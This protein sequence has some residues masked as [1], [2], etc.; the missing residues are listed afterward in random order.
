[1]CD[2]E[3]TDEKVDSASKEIKAEPG[4]ATA[5]GGGLS[6]SWALLSGWEDSKPIVYVDTRKSFYPHTHSANIASALVQ[7]SQHYSG[8]RLTA[9]MSL[10]NTGGIAEALLP[11]FM[12]EFSVEVKKP[13]EIEEADGA[14]DDL[15]RFVSDFITGVRVALKEFP[16]LYAE[17]E[18]KRKKASFAK[19]EKHKMLGAGASNSS[20]TVQEEKT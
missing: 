9:G 11:K 5:I 16:K 18:E 4:M 13:E 3:R 12:G 6:G 8:A 14:I 1:M 10:G 7:T 17:T 15:E 19:D 20:S 2:K